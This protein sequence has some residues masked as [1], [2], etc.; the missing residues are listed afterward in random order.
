LGPEGLSHAL[1]EG[2]T[3]HLYTSI[4]LL[5]SVN[6]ILGEVASLTHII[7]SGK[8]DASA[9]TNL[10]EHHP[11]ITLIHLDEIL[12]AGTEHDHEETPPTPDDLACIMY[13]SGTTGSPKV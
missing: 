8:A 1:T 2:D 9:A 7:Y 5:P 13:T 4:D 10:K 12:K 3:T 6:K 11:K